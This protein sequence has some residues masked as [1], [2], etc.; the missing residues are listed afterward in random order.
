MSARPRHVFLDIGDFY[1][2]GGHTRVRTVLG[3]CVA[4]T[5]WHPQ[6]RVGGI[7]HYLLPMPTES[8]AKRGA[9]TMYAEGAIEQFL[10]EIRRRGAQPGDFV[11]KM[12]GGGSMFGSAP[13]RQQQQRLFPI[14]ASIDVSGMNVEV[15]RKLLREC[16]FA[17]AAEN[18]GGFGSREIVFELWSGDV[19]VRRGPELRCA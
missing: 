1:F 4:I 11:A 18:V 7:C 8:I 3:S 12:F 13:T 16:G 17:I 10:Q 5:V 15:G 2:G 6:L 14:S 9:T 19:W